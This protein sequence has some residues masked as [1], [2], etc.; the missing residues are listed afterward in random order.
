[1]RSRIRSINLIFVA[2]WGVLALC[3]AQ[4][5]TTTIVGTVSDIT[6]AALPDAKITLT[7]VDTNRVQETASNGTGAYRADLLPPGNYSIAVVAVGFQKYVQAGIMLKPGESGR[8]D[9]KLS[10]GSVNQVVEVTADATSVNTINAEIGQTVDMH[11]IQEL[12][13]VNREAYGL[14]DLTPGVQTNSGNGTTPNISFGAPTQVTT[15]NGGM[16]QG[17]GSVNY[18][19]DGGPN[20]STIRNSGN[21]LPNPDALEEFRVQTNSYSAQY[22]RFGGGIINTIIR[23]G[24]NAFHGVAFEFLRNDKLNAN[25]WNSVLAK[26]PL[27]RNQFGFTLGGPVI[28][29]KTFFFTSY[30]GLR[31]TTSSLLSSAVVPTS[32]ELGGDFRGSA[33]IPTD[34]FNVVNKVAQPISCNGVVGVL[35]TSRMDPVAKALLAYVPA[36][37]ASG[38]HWQGNVTSPY[39]TNEF[40][41]KG[42]HDL[43]A[44]HRLSALYFTTSGRYAVNS[45]GNISPYSTTT[46]TWRQ[47]NAN[48]TDTW[49][50]SQNMVNQIWVSMTRMIGNRQSTAGKSLADFGS[51]FTPQGGSYLPN[52][53]VTGY[54]TLGNQISAPGNSSNYYGLRDLITWTLGRHSV[55]FGGDMALDKV[56]QN[57]LLSNYGSASFTGTMT[58][59]GFADY[60]LGIPASFQQDSPAG[61]VQVSWD[62]ALFVQD[63]WHVA[64]RLTIN[65]GARWDIQTPPVYPGTDNES[66][67]VAGQQSTAR[68]NALLGQLFPGDKGVTRGIIPVRLGHFSPRIGF[69]FDPKGDGKTSVRGAFGIFWGSISSTSW[70]NGASA[71]PFAI[72]QVFSNTSSTTGATLSNPY[73]NLAGGNPFPYRGGTWVK[74]GAISPTPLDFNWPYTYQLNFSI[75]RQLTSSLNV[76]A[77]YVGTLTH[78]MPYGVDINYPLTT[79]QNNLCTG[80]TKSNSQLRRPN[81]DF[82]SISMDY[83]NRNAFY[84]GFQLSGNQRMSRHVSASTYYVFSKTLQNVALGGSGV[85]G[86]AQ[87]YANLAAERSRA[88]TDVRHMFRAA[89]VFQPDYYQGKNRVV[90]AALLGWTISPIVRLQSGS[91]F[92]I[93]NGADAN[94]DGNSSTDRAQLIGNPHISN[95]SASMWFNTAAFSQNVAGTV[96]VDGNTPLN[97]LDGPGKK[98]MDLGLSRTFNLHEVL[99]LQFRSEATNVLNIVNLSNPSATVGT[100]TF[101]TITSAQSMRQVQMGLRLSF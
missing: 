53:S 70:N 90:R 36:S 18:Y 59:N 101:G 51:T 45:G 93:A 33:K 49:T 15:I 95:P 21:L 84:H 35:C 50:I 27:H 19:L 3:T 74:G 52:I 17:L 76:M 28:K 100:T 99:K 78:D 85:G 87:D 7:N 72:R 91:P 86:S 31:Q 57:T 30:A 83:S 94:L 34:P 63:D 13:L 89:I 58:G 42:N 77:A 2:L 69:A 79:C 11:Q 43:M 16:D 40:L 10:P 97:F 44:N 29:N 8:V 66:T 47:T 12:P 9:V 62:S 4:V 55:V 23:S 65:L 73:R 1:M 64:P 38:N 68:P 96:P 46:Y 67:Y 14:L 26:A 80:P 20:M 32:A 6:G 24:T 5:T 48:L 54:Y 88:S 60:L 37:N 39:D 98:N 25:N 75:S 56:N 92:T 81:Q 61:D 22:G 71:E 82:G 41:V